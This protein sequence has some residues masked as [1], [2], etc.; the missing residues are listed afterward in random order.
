MN[1]TYKIRYIIKYTDI[2]EIEYVDIV[3]EEF[4]S[5]DIGQYVSSWLRGVDG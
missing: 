1:T 2:M 5:S 4:L 3:A